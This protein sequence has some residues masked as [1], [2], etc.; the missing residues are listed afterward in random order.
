[1]QQIDDEV[2]DQIS[3]IKDNVRN[4]HDYFKPN[5]D[6]FN[7]FTSF[8][9]N[10]SLTEDHKTLLMTLSKPTLE[11]NVL[12]AYISRLLGEFSKQE[13][14]IEVSADN[15]VSVDPKIIKLV[16]QHIRHEFSDSNNE[17][18]KWSIYKDLLAGGYSV[19]KVTTEYAHPMSFNQVLKFA[20]AYDPTLCGFDPLA[21][22]SHKG[23]GSYCFELFPMT[24]DNF[25]KEYPEIDTDDFSF[26][27]D[28]QGFNWSYL[29]DKT[30]IIILAEYY[31]KKKVKK[32]I[33]QLRDG[34]VVT[35]DKYKKMIKEW[36]SI[37]QPPAMIGEARTTEIETIV[38]YRLVENQ[39]IN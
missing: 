5:Y 14:S 25:R 37:E 7:E 11:F 17:H 22:F 9:F 29:N 1:M 21:R 33:V 4:S 20:R 13:P 24:C 32:R 30:P 39:I 8:V 18:V 36:D 27:R 38:R 35:E 10:T 16:E 15:E 34:Q 3:R 12:E 28:F 23:D 6:R 26:R 19:G 2:L 31:E